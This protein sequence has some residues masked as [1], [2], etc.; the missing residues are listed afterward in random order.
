M[1]PRVTIPVNSNRLLVTSKWH[2]L[3]IQMIKLSLANVTLKMP[4]LLNGLHS[5]PGHVRAT[6]TVIT[7][8]IFAIEILVKIVEFWKLLKL[9][10]TDS[11]KIF[12]I[13]DLF[14]ILMFC[15]QHQMSPIWKVASHKPYWT[16]HFLLNLHQDRLFTIE[17]AFNDC[18][19]I[20]T[21]DQKKGSALRLV[22][23]N[24]SHF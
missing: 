6:Q 15:H 8:L 17:Q 11:Q 13:M 10:R 19:A 5:L 4:V 24:W 9:V 12:S 22:V 18:I 16:K 1:V 20:C 23:S 14:E 2:L 21:N 3:Q 7:V